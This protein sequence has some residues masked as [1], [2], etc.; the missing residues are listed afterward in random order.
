[1]GISRDRRLWRILDRTNPAKP[2]FAALSQM[3]AEFGAAVAQ[4]APGRGSAIGAT[5]W[6]IPGHFRALSPHCVTTVSLLIHRAGSVPASETP[7]IQVFWTETNGHMSIC[8]S[9]GADDAQHL[10]TPSSPALRI[11]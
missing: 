4:K 6:C 9:V 8:G 1:M 11:A 7:G 3:I 10:C 5:V 2:V